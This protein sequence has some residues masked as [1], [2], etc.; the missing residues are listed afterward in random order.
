MGWLI[1]TFCV[2][3]TLISTSVV[4]ADNGN[5]KPF[6]PMVPLARTTTMPPGVRPTKSSPS[7]QGVLCKLTV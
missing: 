6:A 4:P 7:L 3:D 1:T 2:I 5:F